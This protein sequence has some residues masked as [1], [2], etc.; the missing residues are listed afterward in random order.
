MVCYKSTLLYA[1]HLKNTIVKLTTT[2][3]T[4]FIATRLV[5]LVYNTWSTFSL[6][7]PQDYWDEETLKYIE[8]TLG[9]FVKVADQTK[10][11]RYTSYARI[12]VYMHIA[13]TLT[14]S[15]MLSHEDTEWVQLL[16]Y[17]HVP[18]KCR[19]CH[20]HGHLYRD[21]PKNK[22]SMDKTKPLY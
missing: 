2:H 21:C 11:Q 3:T 4:N 5:N 10:Q 13:K 12:C 8:N 17:E 20:E 14:D 6:N 19:K 7:F 22:I 16:D 18:F 9:D 1:W 15:I